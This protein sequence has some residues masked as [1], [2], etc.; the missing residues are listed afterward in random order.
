MKEK[1]ELEKIKLRDERI[2]QGR[3]QRTQA[4]IDNGVEML[5]ALIKDTSPYKPFDAPVRE[6][7]S[8][9]L[10]VCLSDI[11]MGLDVYTAFG[12]YNPEYAKEY[13]ETYLEKISEIIEREKIENCYVAILGDLING[14]IHLTTMIE[15][16]DDVITQVQEVSELISWFLYELSKM[17][18]KVYV[19]SVSGNHSRIDKKNEVLRT[20][21]LDSLVVWYAKARLSEQAN[22]CF[23]D[24]HRYDATLAF[25]NIRG[26]QFLLCHGD[27][28]TNDASGI[29]KLTMMTRRVPYAVV[30]GHRHST[31]YSEISGVRVIQ[32][33]TFAGSG[34][35]YCIEKRI[36]GEPSQ[37]V[38]VITNKGIEAL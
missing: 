1:L 14:R 23:C 4:R 20:E 21:R 18:S 28:D 5:A 15:N 11:H 17:V 25:F 34:S 3:E 6:S 26:Y 13:M 2:L 30:M 27:Y 35:D 16:R 36:T 7:A 32:S 19:N 9:D 29:Q 10:L 33:G 22:I 8:K 12:D 38:A 31:A 24:Q 37:A